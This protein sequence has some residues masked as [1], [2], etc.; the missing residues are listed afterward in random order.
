MR[1]TRASTNGLF[2]QPAVFSPNRKLRYALVRQWGKGEGEH[3]TVNFIMCSPSTADD[4]DDDPTIR[5]CVDFAQRWE[6]HRLIVTNVNP[7]RSLWPS[8]L[9][10]AVL[11]AE[12]WATN[13]RYIREAADASALVVACW[14]TDAPRGMAARALGVLDGMPL[15]CLGLNADRSPKHPLRVPGTQQLEPFRS[16]RERQGG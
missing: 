8:A 11:S 15:Y 9:Q 12:D 4:V 10:S 6:Y 16:K 14:G 13:D 5:R 2:D 1:T 3:E 7:F